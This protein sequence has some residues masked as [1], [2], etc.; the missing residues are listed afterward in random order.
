MVEADEHNPYTCLADSPNVAMNE[1]PPSWYIVKHSD[2]YCDIVADKDIA[3]KDIADKNV[4]D[5]DRSV[6]ASED[7]ATVWGPFVSKPD[8]I[9]RRVGLIRSSKCRPR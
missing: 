7:K 3:D 4:A 2:G 5:K 8:A 6:K 9:A 1:Q